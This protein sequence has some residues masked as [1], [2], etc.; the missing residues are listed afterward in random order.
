LALA[1]AVSGKESIA[2]QMIAN[3]ST[4]IPMYF[5]LSGTFGSATRDKAMILETLIELGEKEKAFLVLKEISE[6]M[7]SS[8]YTSTQTTAYA[9]LA[10]S[11]FVKKYPT[12]GNISCTYSINGKTATAKTAKPVYK[13][14]L[15]FSEGEANQFSLKSDNEAMVFVRI[16]RKGIPETGSETAASSNINMD[17]KY[18][19]LNGNPIDVSSIAQGTDFVATVTLQYISG[20]AN[21][22][23]VALS[24]IFPSGWEIIN[25]RMLKMDLGQDS[26][27][28]YQDIRDDRVLTYFN[29][30]KNYT[31]TYRVLLNASFEGK[32]YLPSVLCETMYDDSNYARNKGMWVNVTR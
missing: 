10:A 17:V 18:S 14:E 28:T 6:V 11:K 16:I 9:L 23:N 5:E 31:Y 12:S 4:D 27:Y 29:M 2:K 3:L 25:S 24:Q 26:Y 30:N 7:G 19:Y 32:Y 1:Y 13:T 8:R 22:E 15:S 20:I 21:M